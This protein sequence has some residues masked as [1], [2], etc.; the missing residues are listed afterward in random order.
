MQVKP[1][2]TYFNTKPV[3]ET[4]REQGRAVGKV[5]PLRDATLLQSK[6]GGEKNI[7]RDVFEVR[8][9]PDPARQRGN[10]NVTRNIASD[11]PLHTSK[12]ANV[13]RGIGG[14]RPVTGAAGVESLVNR[15]PRRGSPLGSTMKSEWKQVELNKSPSA[16]FTMNRPVAGVVDPTNWAKY[17][18]RKGTGSARQS[19]KKADDS[20][21]TGDAPI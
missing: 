14:T 1:L 11:S 17:D 12:R 10:K 7:G 9:S 19:P 8:A 21:I 18:W 3:K 4:P 15:S 16:K 5:S 13:R 20:V 6:Y 2:V